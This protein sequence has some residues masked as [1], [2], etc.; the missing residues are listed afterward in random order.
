M[1][2][3]AASPDQSSSPDKPSDFTCFEDR[4]SLLSILKFPVIEKQGIKGQVI[5][6]I[7]PTATPIAAVASPDVTVSNAINTS[8]WA[9]R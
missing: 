4:F 3:S 8:R 7:T 1:Q 2:C 9:T 6:I 5:A